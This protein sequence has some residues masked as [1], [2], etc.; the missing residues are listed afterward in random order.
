MR[1]IV[2]GLILA[3]IALV[4]CTAARAAT[5]D[6]VTMPE[7]RVAGKTRMRLNGIGLRT[8]SILGSIFGLRIY[9]AGLYLEQKS[10]NPE[11]ILQSPEHKL[12]D[13]HFLR[14][15]DAADARQA[16]LDGFASNCRPPACYLDPR[17]VQ[18]FL[19]EIPQFHQGDE[20]TLLFTPNGVDVTF[21]G[22]PLGEITDLHFAEA[23]LA[24]FLGPVPPTPRLKQELLGSQE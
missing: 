11:A 12:L 3:A 23:L 16:W 6:G 18:R 2:R 15:V 10:S 17:D 19:A 14:D 8:Y 1:T 4:P 5:L 9:V 24:T 20:T 22:R 13:I 21:N 7:T